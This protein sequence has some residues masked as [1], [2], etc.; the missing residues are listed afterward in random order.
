ME[1]IPFDEKW[2]R[3]M[4]GDNRLLLDDILHDL[5]IG[6]IEAGSK[7]AFWVR[8]FAYF[9]EQ[10]ESLVTQNA[11]GGLIDIAA[12]RANKRHL[13]H[14]ATL[15]RELAYAQGALKQECLIS[16]KFYRLTCDLELKLQEKGGVL[17]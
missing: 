14:I 11:I 5:E 8:K 4:L 6:K 13:V 2:H 3:Q 10:Y 9:Y 7:Q 16:E 12:R 17:S 15:E 1:L